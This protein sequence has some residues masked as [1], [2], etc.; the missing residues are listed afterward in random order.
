MAGFP[1]TL[2]DLGGP[3]VAI[4]LLISVAALAVIVAKLIQFSMVRVGRHG[5]VRLAVMRWRQGDRAKAI[6]FLAKDRSLAASLAG[7]AMESLQTLHSHELDTE[8]RNTSEERLREEISARAADR[9]FRLASWIR[10]LDL[11]TQIAPLLGLFGT[12]LGMIEAFQA[13]QASGASADPAALAGGIWVALLTTAC[14]LAVAIPV[15]VAVTWFEARLE[16]ERAAL[17]ILLTSIFTATVQTPP[18]PV[19][20][21]SHR[22]KETGSDKPEPSGEQ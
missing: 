12:V 22:T 10:A 17:E 16:S 7:A 13:L 14:G 5:T 8:E 6:Q 1:G 21:R 11:V 9:L 2:L 3:V 20:S 4:L 18:A 19:K 15:S